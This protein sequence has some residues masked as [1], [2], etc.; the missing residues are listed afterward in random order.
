VVKEY[1]RQLF[2]FYSG[3]CKPNDNIIQL[4]F[5]AFWQAKDILNLEKRLLCLTGPEEIVESLCSIDFEWF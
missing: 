2:N 1:T 5:C 3:V 4:D